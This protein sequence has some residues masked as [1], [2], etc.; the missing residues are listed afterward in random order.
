MDQSE[1]ALRQQ[2]DETKSHLYENLESLE[3]QVAESVQSTSASVS[4]TVE[5]IQQTAET[6]HGAVNGA[7][8]SWNSAFDY[9]RHLEEHP[10]LMLGGAA[11]VGFLAAELLT[12]H[13]NSANQVAQEM[14]PSDLGVPTDELEAPVETSQPV[15]ASLRPRDEVSPWDDLRTAAFATMVTVLQASAAHIIPHLLQSM[16][17]APATSTPTAPPKRPGSRRRLMP[18]PGPTRMGSL[19]QGFS[20]R[21]DHS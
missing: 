19:R 5:A 3:Q 18:E 12:R 9:R 17:P 15:A 21:S 11:A 7:V 4:A 6:V 13:R 2:I 20:P 16:L 14:H 1:D 10:L 8:H